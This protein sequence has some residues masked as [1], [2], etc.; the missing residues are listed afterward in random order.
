MDCEIGAI[1]PSARP[2]SKRDPKRTRK[3]VASPLKKEHSEK[4]MVAAIR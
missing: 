4:A 1:P 2:I 3:E